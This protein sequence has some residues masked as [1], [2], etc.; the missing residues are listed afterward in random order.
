MSRWQWNAC[1]ASRLVTATPERVLNSEV[2]EEWGG[3]R[4]RGSGERRGRRGVRKEE[5]RGK[6]GGEV[7]VR[8]GE[9]AINGKMGAETEAKHGAPVRV[10]QDIHCV[11]CAEQSDLLLWPRFALP[12][13]T[14]GRRVVNWRRAVA[15]KPDGRDMHETNSRR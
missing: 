15:P 7:R 6:D 13:S 10:P 4:G 12:A 9:V 5:E 14:P 1:A 8:C 2:E 3:P 11:G